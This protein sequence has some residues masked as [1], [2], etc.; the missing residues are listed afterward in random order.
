MLR[1]LFAWLPT[2]TRVELG[3]RAM[4]EASAARPRDG[5]DA[6]APQHS[7]ATTRFVRERAAPP[8]EADLIVR[9]GRRRPLPG[10]SGLLDVAMLDAA[11]RQSLVC[12]R[13]WGRAGLRVGA[14]GAPS[15]PAFASLWC[16]AQAT[17]PP[18]TEAPRRLVD[19][20]LEQLET[21]RPG[22]IVPAHDGT[23]EA[24]RRFRGEVEARTRIAMASESAMRIAVSKPLTLA[25]AESLGILV[26]AGVTVAGE[27]DVDDALETVGLPTVVKPAQS[28]VERDG[29]R[30]RL[31]ST[32][33][34]DRPGVLAAV[35]RAT[36]AGTEVILQPWLPGAREA[37]SLF[38]ADGRVWARFVQVAHRMNPPLGGS[39]VMRESAP[40]LADIVDAAERLIRATGLEGYSETEFRRDAAGRPVLMEINPRL[41][42]SVEIA[43][44]SGVDFPMLIHR[45]AAGQRLAPVPGYRTG[46]RVRW[47]GGDVRWLRAVI[48]KQG[49]PDSPPTARAVGTFSRDFLRPAAYD[50]VDAHDV[51][52]LVTATRTFLRR[53]I[54]KT[55][56]RG[57]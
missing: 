12:V 6:L 49:L 8:T 21:Y 17:L 3:P 37:V 10:A 26:P 57:G 23:I 28:W 2:I 20:I 32:V 56:H 4:G 42:A 53:G 46:V 51:R 30:R 50:Y 25:L 1:S 38:Y 31:A 44:R 27:R 43:V 5:D 15:S 48:Q 19:G 34:V 29:L 33:A 24:L 13:S 35:R 54:A 18:V 9:S 41:S 14:F 55:R 11:E 7:G 40:P 16:A 22:V 39:S 52:P 36:E 45:W 47:L